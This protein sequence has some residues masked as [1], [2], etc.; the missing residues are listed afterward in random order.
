MRI[1][2]LSAP[3]DDKAFYRDAAKTANDGF[4]L[5]PPQTLK[6][7]LYPQKVD[8]YLGSGEAAKVDNPITPEEVTRLL[9]R[10]REGLREFGRFSVKRIDAGNEAEVSVSTRA[11]RKQ[12][13]AKAAVTKA[14]NVAAPLKRQKEKASGTA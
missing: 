5:E 10:L 2:G 13:K 12:K 4:A 8:G 14:A 9:N 1:I 7:E 3:K 6:V 11:P